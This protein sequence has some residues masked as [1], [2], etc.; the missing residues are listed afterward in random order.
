MRGST[1]LCLLP[2]VCAGA[3]AA[4]PPSPAPT[5]R[6]LSFARIT[7][8]MVAFPLYG[9]RSYIEAGFVCALSIFGTMLFL[10][11]DCLA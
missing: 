4:A 2:K 11:M 8:N 1:L 10:R 5:A 3:A 9:S 7:G 6:A